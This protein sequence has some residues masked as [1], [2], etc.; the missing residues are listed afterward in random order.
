V[1]PERFP[2]G[3][4]S[5]VRLF[6]AGEFF[7]AHEAFEELLDQVEGDERWECLV[8]L[9]QVA[10]G[11]H[12]SAAGHPGAARMLALGSA[13]LARFPAIF[14]GLAVERLRRLVAE[15]LAVLEAGGSLASRRAR[16]E[17]T[18]ETRSPPS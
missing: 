10:V 17:M 4:A 5:G 2:P 18:R 15:D 3:F 12:K 8:A 16:L 14:R 13:K 11:Y 7:A 9:V 1:S 6:N